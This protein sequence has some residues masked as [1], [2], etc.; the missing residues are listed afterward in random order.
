M[1]TNRAKTVKIIAAA[2]FA[3]AIIAVIVILFCTNVFLLYGNDRSMTEYRSAAE[4]DEAYY[5]K[6]DECNLF[7]EFVCIDKATGK[8]T[9]Q[10]L[11]NEFENGYGETPSEPDDTDGTTHY[12]EWTAENGKHFYEPTA[13]VVLDGNDFPHRTV[14]VA[15]NYYPLLQKITEKHNPD[16][17]V[18][19]QYHA[20]RINGEVYG[21]C[22]VYSG[23]VG[24]FAGGGN[25]GVEKIIYTSFFRYAPQYNAITEL[26]RI[27][28]GNAVAYDN[29]TL[30][31]YKDKKYYL[32]N[33][34]GEESY[35]CDDLAFDSGF[36]AYSY[37][38]FFFDDRRLVIVQKKRFSIESKDFNYIVICDM[39]GKKQFEHRT[40]HTVT[41]LAIAKN[42]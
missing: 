20:T 22:N 37:C 21:F 8:I 24:F 17:K 14:F 11:E 23:C 42:S 6:T 13:P 9:V 4:T 2:I 15:N 39:D 29:D 19:I 36:T 30:F 1:G 5:Y 34:G 16:G 27:D 25:I 26:L 35:I 12:E 3:I 28:G 41:A 38:R 7:T 18:Q 32:Q 31:F 10:Q 40:E 33:L